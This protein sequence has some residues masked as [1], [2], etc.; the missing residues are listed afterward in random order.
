MVASQ[1]WFAAAQKAELSEQWKHGEVLR[2]SRGAGKEEQ[3]RIERSWSPWR[4]R[5]APRQRALAALTLRNVKNFPGVAVGRSMQQITRP[6]TG[7][8]D[9]KPE[10]WARRQSGLSCRSADRRVWG[11]RCAPSLV[12]WCCIGS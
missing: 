11:R 8:I 3:D 1:I 5:A 10:I 6:R 4:G 12:V 9:R 7:A 2:P